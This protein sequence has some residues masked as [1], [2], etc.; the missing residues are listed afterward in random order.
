MNNIKKK[1]K[2]YNNLAL[3]LP[4]LCSKIYKMTFSDIYRIVLFVLLLTIALYYRH[5]EIVKVKKQQKAL[6]PP[7]I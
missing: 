2:C 6:N 4:H 3:S 5:T 7:S 1:Q